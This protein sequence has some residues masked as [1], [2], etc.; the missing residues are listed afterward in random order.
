MKTLNLDIECAPALAYIWDLKTRYVTPDKIVTPKRMLCFAGKWL[1]DDDVHFFSEWDDGTEA[2]LHQ[3][4]NLL[5]QADA[6]LHYNGRRFDIPY[7][8]TEFAQADLP[9]PSPY[10]Q[11]DLYRAVT[12]QF[13]FMSNSLDS[14]SRALGTARKL[15]H[16]GFG[17]WVK[18][19]D[20]DPRARRQMEDYNCGDLFANEDLYRKILP[21]IPSHPS[22]AVIDGEDA[23]LTCPQCGS[24]SVEPNG[25]AYTA[26]STY[27]RY[28]CTDCGKW[29]RGA[30]RLS[31]SALRAAS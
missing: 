17:L 6:V 22:Y 1:G 24:T 15:G 7:I 9:P 20:G 26:V 31:G 21:W 11:I 29:L 25:R 16:E 13:S 5:D 23:G 8:N 3:I 12:R 19:L 2:M 18:V 14:V 4:W 10:A 30:H 27:P 28:L